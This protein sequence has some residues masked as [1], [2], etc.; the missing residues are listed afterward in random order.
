MTMLHIFSSIAILLSVSFTIDIL[1]LIG[2]GNGSREL[3]RFY[4]K[5]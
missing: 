5:T 3:I 2:I 1:H 4:V